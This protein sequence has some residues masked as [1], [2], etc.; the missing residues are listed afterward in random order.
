MRK[1][2]FGSMLLVLV[3]AIAISIVA[4][5]AWINLSNSFTAKASDVFWYAKPTW[6]DPTPKP[7]PK[8]AEETIEETEEELD[9][10]EELDNEED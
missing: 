7:T 9:S 3:F 2:D 4:Y 1:L 6:P 5:L 8:P 10:E